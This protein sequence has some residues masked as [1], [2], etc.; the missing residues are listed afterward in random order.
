MSLRHALL[1]M[2]T[3]EPMTGYQLVKYFDGTVAFVWSAPHS[4]IY[5]ELRRME[6]DGLVVA[7]VVRRGERARKRVYS[8]TDAGVAE[9][10]RWETELTP[11]PAGRDP[12]RLKAAFFEW[13]SLD[14]ARRQLREHLHHYR[15]A[16]AVWEGVIAGIDHRSVPLLQRRLANRPAREHPAIVAVKRFAFSGE[17]ARAKAEIAWA[18]QGLALLDDLGRSGA[19]LA[20]ETGGGEAGEL[21]G[22]DFPAGGAQDAGAGA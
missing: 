6:N 14:A 12:Y 22:R 2:L 3:A 16:L 1:A 13:G 5:P 15:Q 17:V 11:Y 4:Q 7:D 9:L 8:I 10:H 21:P 20:W 18:E 19:A